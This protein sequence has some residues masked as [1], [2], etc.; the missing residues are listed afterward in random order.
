MHVLHDDGA[1]FF[2]SSAPYT[3]TFRNWTFE[4]RSTCAAVTK[5]CP[6]DTSVIPDPWELRNV[7]LTTGTAVMVFTQTGVNEFNSLAGED[8]FV[9]EETFAHVSFVPEPSAVALSTAALTALGLI[10]LASRRRRR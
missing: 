7:D 3:A 5:P 1:F 9:V 8:I 6:V 10:R 4:V 2:E